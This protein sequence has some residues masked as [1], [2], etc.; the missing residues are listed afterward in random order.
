ML[1]REV[2]GGVAAKPSD[3]PALA[4]LHARTALQGLLIGGTGEAD[5][6]RTK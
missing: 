6:R 2:F 3:L 4:E 1:F 5:G